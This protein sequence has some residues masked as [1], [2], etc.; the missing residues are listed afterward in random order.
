VADGATYTLRHGDA[1]SSC[2]S[3]ELYE[4]GVTL[5]A[6]YQRISDKFTLVRR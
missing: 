3:D 6:N 1:T 5:L 2:T 4:N